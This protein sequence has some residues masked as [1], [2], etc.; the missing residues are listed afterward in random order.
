MK[1][2]MV[3]RIFPDGKT[4]AK[5]IG[6]KGKQCTAYIKKL[7]ELLNAQTV[8]SEFTKEYY[9]SQEQEMSATIMQQDII[10]D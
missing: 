10:K 7:E 1:K 3:V 5:T 6:I 4:E 8:E 9:Q 2:Q